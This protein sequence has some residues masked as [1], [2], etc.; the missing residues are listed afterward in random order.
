MYR[1]LNGKMTLSEY[2]LGMAWFLEDNRWPFEAAAISIEV[3]N[4]MEEPILKISNHVCVI[5]DSDGF[6][7]RLP[8]FPV[9]S[10]KALFPL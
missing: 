6:C 10:N 4:S 7:C 1:T 8:V 9:Y 3:R 5:K 2:I